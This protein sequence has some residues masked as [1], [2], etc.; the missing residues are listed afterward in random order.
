VERSRKLGPWLV[1]P[2]VAFGQL[3]VVV[4]V[5]VLN[6]ALPALARDLHTDMAGLEWAIIA[7]GLTMIGLVPTFGRVSD[8]LGRKRLYLV[9]LLVFCI[10]SALCAAAHEVGWLVAARVV[11]AAGGALVTS[12]ALAILTDAFPTGRR[13]VAM[14]VQSI[15]ISG[16]AAAGPVIGG[17][18]VTRFGWEAVFLVNLPVGG[19]TMVYAARVL[20]SV[21]GGTREPMD[22][23]GAGLLLVG[24]STALLAVT[25][26]PDWGW[27]ARET[28]GSLA[29]GVVALVLFALWERRAA[30]P[31]VRPSLLRIRALTHGMLAG[32]LAGLTLTA[33]VFLLPFYWQGLRGYEALDAGLLMFPL[34]LAIAVMSPLAGRYSD[35]RGGRGVTTA[36][37]VLAAVGLS[38]VGLTGGGTSVPDFLW[39]YGVFGLGMGMFL[40]PNNNSVMSAAPAE[41]RGVASGLL[42]LT[43][44]TGQ[45]LGIAWG[46]TVFLHAVGGAH[47]EIPSPEALASVAHD[48]ELAA[49]MTA[50]FVE[51]F[52]TA[53]LATVPI[54]LLGAL[55]SA[56]R[57]S[58]AE[59]P[60][61]S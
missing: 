2:A 40:A 10:G 60:H 42:V 3:M 49:R 15:L 33:V 39:R 13:G 38:L 54:T 57:G 8:V 21:R 4:D 31:L 46:G 28:L 59:P 20:P 17:F 50:P 45:S 12:N 18:L 11:Q 6:I 19:V 61:R 48:P 5:T 30:S 22:W 1:L 29:A 36:G 7:Y 32:M 23:V 44:F 53:C 27:T 9:G 55:L 43:R 47:G 52:R 25:K 51:G 41:H 16:G 35:L 34:P 37:L 14:G 58:S 26:A 56:R 24:L